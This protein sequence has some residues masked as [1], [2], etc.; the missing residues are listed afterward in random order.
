MISFTDRVKVLRR[1]QE[2]RNILQTIKRS[3]ANWIG[4]ILLSKCLLNTLLKER[5]RK[6]MSDETI[7]EKTSA[8]T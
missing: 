5:K 2:D 8:A 3:E 7:R 4:H 1:V 6:S